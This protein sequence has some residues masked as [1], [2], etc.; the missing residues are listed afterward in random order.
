MRIQAASSTNLTC[1]G[2]PV[3]QKQCVVVTYLLRVHYSAAR[4]PCTVLIE[5]QMECI[6]QP[7]GKLSCDFSCYGMFLFVEE[8]F[9]CVIKRQLN[10]R[11]SF[12]KWWCNMVWEIL[13]WHSGFSDYKNMLNCSFNFFCLQPTHSCTAKTFFF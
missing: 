2:N 7:R 12:R 11:L 3:T 4:P 1:C 10:K 6:F 13:L 8:L 5:L 9:F